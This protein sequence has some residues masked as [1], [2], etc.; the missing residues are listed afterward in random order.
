MTNAKDE[1]RE[2]FTAEELANNAGDPRAACGE[3]QAEPA[4]SAPIEQPQRGADGVAATEALRWQS[5]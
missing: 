1:K 5:I 2:G 4:A 3:L